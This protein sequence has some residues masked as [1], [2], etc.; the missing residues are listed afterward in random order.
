MAG[1]APASS[2]GRGQRAVTGVLLRR[3]KTYAAVGAE[4]HAVGLLEGTPG[5]YLPHSGMLTLADAVAGIAPDADLRQINV[6]R[7]SD[8]VELMATLWVL[9]N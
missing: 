7:E 2:T 9:G 6:D 5:G 3:L 1:E 4:R 8:L